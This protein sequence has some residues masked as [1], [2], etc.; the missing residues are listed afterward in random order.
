MKTRDEIN[1]EL[2]RL[3][4]EREKE[5]HIPVRLP[6]HS[7]AM[8]YV[9]ARPVQYFEWDNVPQLLT[10]A[11]CGKNFGASATS[12]DSNRRKE[13]PS[14]DK[15]T[16]MDSHLS[17]IMFLPVIFGK[18]GLDVQLSANCA[19]CVRQKR[20]PP[21]SVK[22]RLPD[23]P[24]YTES[25]PYFEGSQLPKDTTVDL[26]NYQFVYSFLKEVD[27]YKYI[28][29]RLKTKWHDGYIFAGES[30]DYDFSQDVE[31]W[32][33]IKKLK[34]KKTN[35]ARGVYVQKLLVITDG[36]PSAEQFAATITSAEL[37]S[38][39]IWIRLTKPLN[40]QEACNKWLKRYNKTNYYEKL[41]K[42]LKD[43]CGITVEGE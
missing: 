34:F 39:Y 6:T 12:E 36:T 9:M 15:I 23:A 31:I 42:L 10:C 7:L 20:L 41:I 43:I 18:I 26:D 32:E 17:N 28:G 30:L 27:D 3:R 5:G 22:M 33:Q 14:P 11:S 2:E 8:C 40:W 21:F 24:E 29:A 25:V 13:V 1:A 37:F 19:E 4:K 16:I 38:G 35:P